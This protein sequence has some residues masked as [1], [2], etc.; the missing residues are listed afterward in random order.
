M[1][2]PGFGLVRE[3]AAS[4][5]RPTDSTVHPRQYQH[6]LS[7]GEVA[8]LIAAYGHQQESIKHS[9]AMLICLLIIGNTSENKIP[10]RL[11]W[12]ELLGAQTLD[13]LANGCFRS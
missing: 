12:T 11:R 13:E 6:R 7:K 1:A 5:W 10:G 3:A 4:V 2:G 9:V 8:E